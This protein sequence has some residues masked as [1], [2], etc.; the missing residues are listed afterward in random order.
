MLLSF[1]SFGA[2]VCLLLPA[3]GQTAE[4]LTPVHVKVEDTTYLGRKAVKVTSDG[5]QDGFALL[6]GVEFEDGTIEADIAVKLLTPPGVRMP[7]FLGLAFRARP[8]ASHYELFYLRPGN[9][10]SADQSMRNHTVQY[11]AEP[12]FGWYTLRRNWPWVYEAHAAMKLEQWIHTKV[13]VAGRV[14]KLYVNGSA[15]PT[16]IV[17][18]LKGEDLKGGVALWGYP[19]EEAYFANVKVTPAAPSGVKNGSEAAGTWT[20][21]SSTDTGPANGTLTLKRDGTK[22][23]GTWSGTYGANLPVEGVWREGYL[24]LTFAGEWPRRNADD[25]TPGPAKVTLAGWVDGAEGHGRMKVEGRTD[26]VWTAE[27]KP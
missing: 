1:R 27:R 24:E 23:T 16:L 6:K 20:V 25:P 7:G 12:G 13:E 21:K 4:S 5:H 15:E 18:G 22:L 2:L 26:G 9:S 8:D 19:S 17:D 11:S 14:A 10:G 3:A